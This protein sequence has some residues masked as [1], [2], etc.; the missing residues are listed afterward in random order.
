MA[1]IRL[2]KVI[3]AM[4]I[5]GLP[6]SNLNAQYEEAAIKELIREAYENGY[7]NEGIVRNLELGF[8]PEFRS[9][10]I[11]DGVAR[12]AVR[13]DWMN[14]V[15]R[16]KARREYPLADSERYSIFYHR[17]EINGQVAHV[18]INL[19]KNGEPVALQYLEIYKSPTGWLILGITSIPL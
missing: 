5:A 18:K 7:L 9:V 19:K 15:E 1:K 13:A 11:V 12:T 6:F 17:L 8:S 10:R 16:R 4:L 2:V 3:L 14:E